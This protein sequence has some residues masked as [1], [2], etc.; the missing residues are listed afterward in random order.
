MVYYIFITMGNQTMIYY[1][2]LNFPFKLFIETYKEL[3]YDLSQS[4]FQIWL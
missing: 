4:I 2:V 3:C 1:S